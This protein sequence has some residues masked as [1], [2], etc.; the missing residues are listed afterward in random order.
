[1]VTFNNHGTI[2]TIPIVAANIT[3]GYSEASGNSPQTAVSVS[4][5]FN[6]NRFM[7][8]AGVALRNQSSKTT[9]NDNTNPAESGESYSGSSIPINVSSQGAEVVNSGN[10]IDVSNPTS[11]KSRNSINWDLI[12][13]Q[14]VVIARERM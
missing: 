3:S 5:T 6:P 10:S 11:R 8:P 13:E 12:G 4:A 1:V 2:Q 14:M 7:G 9:K